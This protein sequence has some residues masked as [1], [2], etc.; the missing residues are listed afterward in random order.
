[1]KESW[2]TQN[3]TVFAVYAPFGGDPALSA[4]PPSA[5]NLL[6]HQLVRSLMDVANLGV[7]VVLLMDRYQQDTYLLEFPAGDGSAVRVTSKWKEGMSAPQT[8]RGFLEF[9]QGAH[10]GRKIVLSAEGHGIAFVPEVDKSKMSKDGRAAG[11]PGPAWQLDP[12]GPSISPAPTQPNA[13]NPALP[14]IGDVLPY[15]GDVLPYIGDVLPY[16]GDVLPGGVMSTWGLG[17]ALRQAIARG[18]D[19]LPVI[20]FN[21]CFNFS[22]EVLHT[23]APFAEFATG[24]SNYNFFSAGASYASVF[25]HVV[26]GASSGDVARAFAE[27][28]H[29][30]LSAE[31][32]HPTIGGAFALSMAED[33]AAA[34]DAL[35]ARM[36]EA[37]NANAANRDRIQQAITNAAQYDANFDF[38][39]EVPDD[40]TDVRGFAAA[41]M[42]VFGPA[43]SVHLAAKKLFAL[44]AP[45][46]VYGDSGRPWEQPQLFWNFSGDLAFNIYL[47]DPLRKGI[48]DWR[49]PF[50]LCNVVSPASG[51]IPA[52]TH[53]IEFLSTTRWVAF[54]KKFHEKT[55]W[56]GMRE[57][58]KP[59]FPLF[60]PNGGEIIKRW[61]A[62]Y[63]K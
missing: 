28:N 62:Q 2:L 36:I 4:F 43:E 1:M 5:T 42:N 21:N 60:N 16:I 33:V 30:F 22:F 24:Y 57:I 35:A 48:W 63:R 25:Q 18:V 15:I 9:A 8:L 6:D 14:Y 37:M 32:G 34:V 47:P 39:L 26:Q 17:D 19:V 38:T 11:K 53:V 13:T 46:K 7:P 52:Q 12:G 61:E 27:A 55:V 59:V 29:A 31:P 49:A 3:N 56:V 54:I 58:I 45:F 50:Y 40:F 20:H 51:A 44:T 41:L 10:C 23:I